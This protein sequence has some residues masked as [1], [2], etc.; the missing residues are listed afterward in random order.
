MSTIVNTITMI[1]CDGPKCASRHGADSAFSLFVNDE[2][3]RN[4][5]DSLPDDFA[6]L[7]KVQLSPFDEKLVE[8]CGKGCLADYMTYSYI[9]PKSPREKAA[10]GVTNENIL[11]R[12]IS[13][14]D[15]QAEVV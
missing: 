10:Q 7:I 1:N 13:Q 2:D 4:N 3:L 14:A 6:R 5:P 12:A 9:E 11:A 8:F 15:G